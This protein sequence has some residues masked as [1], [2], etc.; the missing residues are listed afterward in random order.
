[1]ETSAT[2]LG[3]V[4]SHLPESPLPD[5]HFFLLVSLHTAEVTEG[6]IDEG[7][8]LAVA[9]QYCGF[10]SVVWTMWVMVDDAARDCALTSPRI[11]LITWH[12]GRR[13]ALSGGGTILRA[14]QCSRSGLCGQQQMT[15]DRS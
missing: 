9:V 4:C 7:L 6:V 3:I 14:S 5:S 12:H 11:L 10:C 13:T 15:T 8:H 2:L 1:M